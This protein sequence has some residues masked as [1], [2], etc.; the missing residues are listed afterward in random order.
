MMD[1]LNKNSGQIT[2]QCNGKEVKQTQQLTIKLSIPNIILLNGPS[3]KFCAPAKQY[4]MP[5]NH[6]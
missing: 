4:G 5:F 1:N 6:Q 3:T 2:M